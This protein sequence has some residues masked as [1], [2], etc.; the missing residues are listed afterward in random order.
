[1]MDGDFHDGKAEDIHGTKGWKNPRH[2]MGK[3]VMIRMFVN[4]IRK[5]RGNVIDNRLIAINRKRTFVGVHAQ[6]VDTVKVIGVGMGVQD[7]VN[8]HDVGA[9]R[10]QA[11]LRSRIDDE[12]APAILHHYG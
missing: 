7:G 11:E 2:Q 9:E 10:L 3:A 5:S 6:I 12:Y 8:T 1:M 4:H